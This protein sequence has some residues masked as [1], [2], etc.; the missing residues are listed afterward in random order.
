MRH[1][2]PVHTKTYAVTVTL[3]A[4]HLA[5]YGQII[6]HSVKIKKKT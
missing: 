5:C 4:P 6:E 1:R 2:R 3:S